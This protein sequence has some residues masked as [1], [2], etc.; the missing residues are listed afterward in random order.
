MQFLLCN[1]F[2]EAVKDYAETWYWCFNYFMCKHSKENLCFISVL[3]SKFHNH[4]P[5]HQMSKSILKPVATPV[6][7]PA[8][9]S[10]TAPK[11]ALMPPGKQALQPP[12]LPPPKP[13]TKPLPPLPPPKP[14][15]PTSTTASEQLQHIN[16]VHGPPSPLMS[17]GYDV[18]A[19]ENGEVGLEGE[20]EVG[21][22][23]EVNDPPLF[24][25]IRW[26]GRITGIFEPVAGIE[27]VRS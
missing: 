19:R 10:P 11:V 16:G 12:P 14:H 22:M 21:S 9:T 26:I 4:D 25:V 3:E 6:T 5:A 8:P 15:S 2:Y 18:A 17:P 24:G 20:L 13:T 1:M 23:V 27:L 7:K